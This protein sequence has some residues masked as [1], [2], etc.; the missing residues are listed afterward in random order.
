MPFDIEG[1]G[2]ELVVKRLGLHSKPSRPT[3]TYST[4]QVF[5][6]GHPVAALSGHMCERTGPGDNSQHGDDDDLRIREG[7]Y[8]VSTQFGKKYRS[9][10][11]TNDT[12]RP[13]PGFLLLDT[14]PRTA[15]L[16]HPGHPPNLFIS[17]VGCLKSDRRAGETAGHGVSRIASPGHRHARQLE[18]A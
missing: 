2:W 16:V 4:Y 1:H 17:A 3:R 14:Q 7:R 13:M 10:G 8:R 9:V 11:Y 15:I 5:I 12:T 18:G 6:D